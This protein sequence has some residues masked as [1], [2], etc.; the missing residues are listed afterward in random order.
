MNNDP[1]IRLYFRIGIILMLLLAL[2][3]SVAYIDLGPYN[4]VI[5]L[6]IAA[7]KATL[8]GY[9]FMHI[10]TSPRLVWTFAIGGFF[11]LFILFALTF[12]DFLSRPI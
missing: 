11:W 9:F 12:S 6:L 2:T 3:I 1:S 4:I 7:V 5:A 10:R 8:V